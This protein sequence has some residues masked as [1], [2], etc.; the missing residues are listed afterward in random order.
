MRVD[1]CSTGTYLERAARAL[2]DNWT[3]SKLPGYTQQLKAGHIPVTAD[4]VQLLDADEAMQ[5]LQ[6]QQQK[7]Q[8]QNKPRKQQQQQARTR[9]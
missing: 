3:D 9:K 4:N 7:Q 5:L 1:V 6:R 2:A 8:Q